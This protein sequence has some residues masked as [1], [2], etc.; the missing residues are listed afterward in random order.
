MVYTYPGCCSH[1]RSEGALHM[2][3]IGIV[4]AAA[5]MMLVVIFGFVRAFWRKESVTAPS[6]LAPHS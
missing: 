6:E 2:F 4:I 3:H 5:G 1:S